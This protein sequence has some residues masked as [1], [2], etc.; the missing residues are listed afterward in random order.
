MIVQE[1][2]K[3]ELKLGR[4]RKIACVI[5]CIASCPQPWSDFY[6]SSSG[7][8]HVTL[9]DM[10]GL[11]Q[12]LVTWHRGKLSTSAGTGWSLVASS[13]GTAYQYHLL[14]IGDDSLKDDRPI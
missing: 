5:T 3:A 1:K 8:S 6:T 14:G 13:M 10:T 9:A 11:I 7:F 4:N 12:T 2:G